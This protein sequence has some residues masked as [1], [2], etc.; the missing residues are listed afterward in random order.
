MYTCCCVG[1]KRLEDAQRCLAAV[2]PAANPGS[3]AVLTAAQGVLEYGRPAAAPVPEDM[4]SDDEDAGMS[5]EQPSAAMQTAM[6]L[7]SS[8]APSPLLFLTAEDAGMA[9]QQPSA[10]MQTAMLLDS[11][12]LVPKSPHHGVPNAEAALLAC[13]ACVD[14]FGW[15]TFIAVALLL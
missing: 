14:C 12:T 7:D 4:M 3:W 8:T 15:Y 5:P 13:C 9:S 1:A 2:A 11:S 6:L 10:A